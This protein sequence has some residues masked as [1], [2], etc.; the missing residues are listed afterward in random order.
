[1]PSKK[2]KLRTIKVFIASPGDLAVERAA[3]KEVIDELN[4][5][6]GDGARVK[7][8]AL[9]W[10]D[11]L[12]LVGRRSQAVINLEVDRCDVFILAMHR[13]WGQDA[14]DSPYSSYTEEEFHRAYDRW[15]NA[16]APEIFVFFKHIDPAS[17]ADPGEQL[18]KVLAFRK[19][20]EDS[21]HVLYHGFADENEF[22]TEVNRH[23]RAY[24]KDELPKADMQPRSIILP[25]E[26]MEE[27]E[28]ARAEAKAATERAEEASKQLAALVESKS[29]RTEE[30]LE[31]KDRPET[32]F[33]SYSH[34]D[35]RSLD[36]LKTM[37]SPLVRNKKL[38]LWD[39]TKIKPGEKWKEQIGNAIANAK[40]AV[41]FVSENFLASDFIAENELP[42]ILE[43]E[44]KKDLT[45][46]WVCL[47]YCLW[48]ETPIA[49]YQAAHDPDRPLASLER[50]TRSRVL[51]EICEEIA[52]AFKRVPA[53]SQSDSSA[54]LLSA[55]VEES[56]IK[57]AQR[58]AQAALEGRVEEARQDFARATDGTTNLKVLY[59][60]YS[61]YKRIGDLATAEEMLER[62]LAISGRDAE[63][64]DTAAAFGNLGVIYK[65]RGDLDEAEK[66]F[67]KSLEMEEKLG[68][69]EGMAIQYGNLGVIYQTRGDLDEAEK[70][71]RKALEINEKLGR[72]EG[73]AN[74]YCCLG[75]I[76]Q[77]RGDLDEAEKMHRKALEIDEKLGRLEGMANDYANLGLIYETRGNL[78]EARELW[79]KARDLFRKIGMPHMVNKL[80]GWLDSLP[81]PKR[82]KKTKK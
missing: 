81:P 13:R 29:V 53:L 3:F 69:L 40:V 37:L 28:K 34:A 4:S 77:T 41:L 10:E 47:N 43:R 62:W 6:F 49:S 75:V 78:D 67:R 59:L 35:S 27:L 82:R 44:R 64:A 60:A 48:K 74:Q 19:S 55:R 23:L 51:K 17:M 50:S 63:T 70:M 5:G 16:K 72:L 68:R 9:G 58:A 56:A 33:I 36:E 66:M 11:T 15:K 73:M 26:V 52:E 21:R 65:T 20:L 76:Y 1:M 12:A 80:Q 31:I 8:E 14:P 22:K 18:K 46:L 2:T 25:P 79:T 54:N 42:P 61:F 32:I 39:D 24:A 57:R 7:F 45:V 71:H 38:E 30:P